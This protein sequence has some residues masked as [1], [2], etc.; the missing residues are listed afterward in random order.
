MSGLSDLVL[1]DA[2][3]PWMPQKIANPV[4]LAPHINDRSW[5]PPQRTAGPLDYD[6]D[7][8]PGAYVW[9][10][11]LVAYIAVICAVDNI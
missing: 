3:W 2:L 6:K 4:K 7:C 11:F 5:P 9:L 8:A 10:L 1:D